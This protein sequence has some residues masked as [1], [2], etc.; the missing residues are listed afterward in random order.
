MSKENYYCFESKDGRIRK[1]VLWPLF[2]SNEIS[3]M[4]TTMMDET[5]VYADM[6]IRKCYDKGLMLAGV[7]S[8]GEKTFYHLV[9]QPEIQKPK[10]I[11]RQP[12]IDIPKICKT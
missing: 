5:L 3:E 1:S 8:V 9:K 6:V 10:I 12:D 4:R 2:T 11:V 7:N